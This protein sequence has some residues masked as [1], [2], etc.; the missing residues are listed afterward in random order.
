MVDLRSRPE[1][2]VAETLMDL[3]T[4]TVTVA[5]A[6]VMAAHHLTAATTAMAG[7][8]AGP[9]DLAPLAGH[10]VRKPQPQ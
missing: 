6:R 1:Q 10:L 8:E 9:T 4:P 7:A 3:L 2:E 5:A